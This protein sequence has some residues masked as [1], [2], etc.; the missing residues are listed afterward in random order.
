[1]VYEWH[2]A[3]GHTASIMA[4]SL[5]CC[6]LGDYLPAHM[7][8]CLFSLD[9]LGTVTTHTRKAKAVSPHYSKT[10]RVFAGITAAGFLTIAPATIAFAADPFS[11]DEIFIDQANAISD[12]DAVIEA[13][14][15][16]PGQ[17]LS[18]VLVDSFGGLSAEDWAVQAYSASNFSNSQALLAISVGDSELYSY[19]M[20]PDGVTYEVL[21]AATNDEAL[22]YLGNGEWEDGIVAIAQNVETMVESGGPTRSSGTS[23][24]A[25]PLIGGV[26]AVGAGVAG[27]TA[28]KNRKKKKE[29]IATESASLESLAQ[30][31]STELL[32][33]DDEVRAGSAE[34]EFARAEFGLEATQQFQSALTKAS[35]DVQRAFTLRRDLEDE[36]PETPAQQKQ[37]NEEILQ[38]AS[39]ARAAMAEQAA[40]FTELRNLA[41]R[42]PEKISELR[43]RAGEIAAAMPLATDQLANLS[44]S[45]PAASLATLR[46][47]PEQIASLLDSVSANLAQAE[48]ELATNDRNGAVGYAR[49]AEGTLQQA[50]QLKAKID[51]APQLL[52]KA[53]ETMQAGIRSLS[54][55]IEDAKRLGG[56]DQTIALRRQQAE[57][58]IARATSNSGVDLIAMT[59]Q[60][61][62]AETNLDLALT[63]VRENDENNRRARAAADKYRES[64][65]QRIA[66][67][68]E[69]VTRYRSI[70]GQSSRTLLEKAREA[71]ANA[72]KA[73]TSSAPIA[74]QNAAGL[75]ERAERAITSDI[76][77]Y[78]QGRATIGTGLSR[79]G[80]LGGEIAGAILT[81]VA[82]S[83]IYGGGFG[84][85]GFGGGGFG[86]GGFGGGGGG[87]GFGGGKSF[88]GGG[89]KGF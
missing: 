34:L 10:S 53:R 52:S 66:Q 6:S 1:M 74:W 78:T 44:H 17:N 81:G 51:D 49:M 27:V 73:P 57:E 69:S 38:L 82:R 14:E 13:L 19:S 31:A 62:E 40:G 42:V 89:R 87:G 12:D 48:N 28:V 60:L 41:A 65:T 55:D 32:A 80:Q 22:N 88:G 71:V 76:D 11:V 59:D 45:F 68:D 70:V 20:A 72:Q 58:V 37:M 8:R 21:D 84:G 79:G 18:V 25:W 86:G 23:V 43:T 83:I 77:S 61:T 35:S 7:L 26:A 9:K 24:N 63:G 67:L 46:T 5:P 54:S 16:I 56:S 29:E 64:L 39:A 30:R 15:D 36:Y 85:G 4:L 75:T 2:L 47:Y 50:S 3:N 33:A